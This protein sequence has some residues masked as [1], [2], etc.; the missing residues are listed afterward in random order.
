MF[1]LGEGWRWQYMNSTSPSYGNFVVCDSC[2][3]PDVKERWLAAGALAYGSKYTDEMVLAVKVL[4]ATAQETRLCGMNETELANIDYEAEAG[5]VEAP[6]NKVQEWMRRAARHWSNVDNIVEEYAEIIAEEYWKAP[7]AQPL[8]A[9]EAPLNKWISPKDRLPDEDDA[10][11]IVASHNRAVSPEPTQN[12]SAQSPE[13]QSARKVLAEL[14]LLA[15]TH[16]R[17]L[18]LMNWKSGSLVSP[19]PGVAKEGK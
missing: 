10:R 11:E 15:S 4:K 16:T 17:T 6:L 2:D 8:H 1:D 5:P 9:V 18:R 12:L 3:G 14:A 7:G 13:Y 19:E